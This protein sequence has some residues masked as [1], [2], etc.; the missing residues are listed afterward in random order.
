[1]EEKQAPL[2]CP[3]CGTILASDININCYT[4]KEYEIDYHPDNYEIPYQEKDV[5][6]AESIWITEATCKCGYRFSRAELEHICDIADELWTYDEERVNVDECQTCEFY[7]YI[8]ATGW[9][10]KRVCAIN[11]R[12]LCQYYERRY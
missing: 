11:E 12:F 8:A 5:S 2:S 6:D 9:C 4:I 3:K 10:N 7:Q 1:M